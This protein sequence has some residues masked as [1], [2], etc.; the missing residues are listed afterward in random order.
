VIKFALLEESKFNHSDNVVVL[1]YESTTKIH[2][3]NTENINIRQMMI[4]DLPIILEIDNSAFDLEWRNS[5]ESLEFAF[6]QSSYTSVAESGD[7]IVGFQFSTS[8]GI[9]GHLARLAVKGAY[10]GKGIGYFLVYDVLNHFK[11]IRLMNVTVNTQQ[12]NTA[13]LALYAN[14]GF[15]STGESYSVYKYFL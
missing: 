12:S 7:E 9:G 14:A 15:K 1:L 13:S 5:F 6:H 2:N 10:Q 3:P 4:E 11:S 8:S